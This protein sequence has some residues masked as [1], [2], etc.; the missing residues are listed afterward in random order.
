M[1]KCFVVQQGRVRRVASLGIIGLLLLARG[2]D[3]GKQ[4]PGSTSCPAMSAR[5]QQAVSQARSGK[6][7][8]ESAVAGM[9]AREIE[10]AR[11]YIRQHPDVSSYILL[12]ALREQA[13]ETYAVIADET[14]AKVLCAALA[15]AMFLN[16][17]G[18]LESSESYDGKAAKALIK[19]GKPAVHCLSELLGDRSKGPLWGSQEATL[20][21]SLQYRRAD[22]A[23]RYIMLILNRK[24]VFSDDPA[25]RDRLIADLQKELNRG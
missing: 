18:Y 8:I 20:S 9:S 11:G 7:S 3:D 12:M 25:E 23:Y 14:K 5:L 21:S 22:F 13:P 19:I 15:K 16:D 10:V 6:T 24:P 2:C 4:K 17:F 1:C